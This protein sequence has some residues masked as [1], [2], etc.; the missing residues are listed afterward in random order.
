MKKI[1]YISISILIFC[2]IFYLS[3]RQ[4]DESNDQS[5]TIIVFL[6]IMTEEEIIDN[7]AKARV[8]SF[9]VRKLAHFSIYALLGVFVYLSTREFEVINHTFIVALLITMLLAGI[10]EVHQ[11]FVPGRSMELRDVI[12]DTTGAFVGIIVIMRILKLRGMKLIN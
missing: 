9:V 4:A 6:R 12:I 8:V 3:S 11:Y 1:I 10:D 2:T 7:P 5:E